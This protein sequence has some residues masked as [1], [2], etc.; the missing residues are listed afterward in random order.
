LV[1]RDD[2][3]ARGRTALYRSEGGVAAPDVPDGTLVLTREQ[4]RVSPPDVLFLSLE[5]L[6]QNMG[7]PAWTR[8]FGFEPMGRKPRLLLLDEVHMYEGIPG[9]QGAW[10]L[11]RWRHWSGIEDL[12]VVG[13]SAT[14]KDAPG[15][16][17]QVAG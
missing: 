10:V 12:H 11:R 3:R 4:L 7:N 16:L 14:L 6:N 5:M 1:W 9:A 15:H 8:A 2:D 13:L 17:A